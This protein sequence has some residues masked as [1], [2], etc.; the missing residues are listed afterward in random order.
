MHVWRYICNGESASYPPEDCHWR[1]IV[2]SFQFG[3]RI[4]LIVGGLWQ[5]AWLFIFGAAGTAKVPDDNPGIG[6]R[7]SLSCLV[8]SGLI[9][10]LLY[11]HDCLCMYVY[12]WICYDMGPVRLFVFLRPSLT[13]CLNAGVCGY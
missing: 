2:G 12:P 13:H 5:A 7:V 4:P 11:S 3:R 6:K 8:A 1:L 9:G 10:G